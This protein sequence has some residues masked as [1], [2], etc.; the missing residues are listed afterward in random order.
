MNAKDY[1][2]YLQTAHWKKMS[3]NAKQK[4]GYRCQVCNSPRSLD[5]HHRTYERLGYERPED[6]ICLCHDCH[7]TY[8]FDKPQFTDDPLPPVTIFYGK[9]DSAWVTP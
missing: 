6:V 2:E 3:A 8:H 5:V 7:A 4:A 9:S 1:A